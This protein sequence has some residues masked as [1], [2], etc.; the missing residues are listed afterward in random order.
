MKFLLPCILLSLLITACGSKEE[1][2]PQTKAM[3]E[4]EQS[5]PY[6]SPGKPS[7]PIT[8]EYSFNSKPE[9]DQPLEVSIKLSHTH[10]ANDV[11]AKINYSPKL[12][13]N[14][15]INAMNFN[16]NSEDNAQLITVTPV[17]NGIH[18]V[19]IQ[20]GT[21]VNGQV[22]Y[23][24]FSIPIEVGEVDWKQH[25]KIEG[26]LNNGS[27]N[28]NSESSKVISLPAAEY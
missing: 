13:E 10:L 4:T 17:E 21:E 26:S 24:A 19:H 3:K 14:Q 15:G 2:K 18:Y 23:K 11:N 22:M 7:A 5:S 25:R 12:I 9:L 1:I 16:N 6:K 8:L 20:A 27:L 28:N